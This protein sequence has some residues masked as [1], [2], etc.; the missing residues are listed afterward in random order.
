[1][2]HLIDFPPLVFLSSIVLLFLAAR[3]GFSLR[4]AL[5]SQDDNTRKD[6]DVVR[7]ATLTLLSLIIGFTFSMAASRYDLRK[8]YE[9]EEANAIGTEFLRVDVLPAADS[10]KLKSLLRSYLDQRISFYQSRNTDQLQRIDS[11]T[12]Q[13]E[14]QLWSA[15][16][17]P[18]GAQP[19]PVSALTIAGMNDVL[20]SRGYTQAAWWNRIPIAAWCLMGAIAIYS[21]LLVG[22]GS[23]SD[24]P[25]FLLL[26][27]LPFIADIDS[28]RGGVI[29]VRPENLI[30]LSQ[31]L[32]GQ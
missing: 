31:S 8:S 18:A 4:T 29:R 11:R 19:T 23:R 3:I 5:R 26:L 32:K 16:Q 10:A 22:Y 12:A 30:S 27:A 1:V 24:Q 25:H 20:N 17:V 21:N 14:S 28:P 15:V 9:E 13:L 7:A 2:K 6:F